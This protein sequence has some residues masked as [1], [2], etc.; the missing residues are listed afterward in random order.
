M[1]GQSCFSQWI[2]SGLDATGRYNGDW[3]G[4]RGIPRAF[5]QGTNR[6][7]P[8]DNLTEDTERINDGDVY[9]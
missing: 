9:N 5:S 4:P 2:T 8:K 7:D 3:D 1:H 6:V